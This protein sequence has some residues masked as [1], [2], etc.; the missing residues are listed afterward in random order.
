MDQLTSISNW[1]TIIPPVVLITCAILTKDVILSIVV[2]LITSMMIWAGGNPVYAFFRLSERAS[3]V[4]TDGEYMRILAFLF[5]LAGVIAM[6]SKSGAVR[7]FGNIANK[8]VKTKRKSLFITYILGILIFIDD[9][10]NAL[11][12]G[13]VMRPL[14]DKN[15][16]SRSKLAFV[17]NS[18]GG[19][20]CILIPI[21]SF[22]VYAMSVINRSPGFSEL[23]VSALNIFLHSVP[24]NF[25]AWLVLAL[26]FAVIFFGKD[27][28]IMKFAEKRA[29]MTNGKKL[30]SSNKYGKALGSAYTEEDKDSKKVYLIDMLL[31][32]IVLVAS[33]FAFFPI[34]G[35]M[36]AI[37]SNGITTFTQ[38]FNSLTLV[39][40]F[41]KTE[42]SKVLFYT[43][44]VT[45]G[46]TYAYY[47]LRKLIS[48]KVASDVFVDGMS[49]T[50]VACL[51][52]TLAWVFSGIMKHDVQTGVYV[53][54]LI[55]N[56]NFPNCF[57][58]TSFVYFLCRDSFFY[59]FI[60]GYIW[61]HDSSSHPGNNR[62]KCS[63]RCTTR[64]FPTYDCS[65]NIKRCNIR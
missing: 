18:T 61:N 43:S 52:L 65:F 51:I 60:M 38:A 59:R 58:S 33:A 12:V 9:Y 15:N 20:I 26:V 21:S 24:Y 32:L 31:P 63:I 50:V 27:F 6:I 37:G 57:S 28:G 1:V 17:I 45:A 53:S 49:T 7:A 14:T 11:T 30:F 22:V 25:Y 4:L 48:Y 39:E 56:S 64:Y 46:F 23:N 34:V 29:E 62:I 54:N 5:I 2:G 55:Q 47:V 44:L 19:P 10:F 16:V 13:A 41:D 40:A 36:E 8:Y 3:D 42:S 35:Y